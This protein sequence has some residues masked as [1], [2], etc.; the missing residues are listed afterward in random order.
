M[1][2]STMQCPK[3]E[4]AGSIELHY[5][6]NEALLAMPK[7]VASTATKIAHTLGIKPTTASNRLAR[8]ESMKL[9]TRKRHGK[10]WLYSRTQK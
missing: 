8:L 5:S 1:K 2:S 4:G 10:E 7:R 9:L 6:L 3:C